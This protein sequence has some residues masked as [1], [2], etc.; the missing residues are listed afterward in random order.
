MLSIVIV[1]LGAS[2]GR[3]AAPKQLGAVVASILAG[4]TWLSPPERRL[5]AACGAG[6]GVAA[7]YNVPFGGALFALEVLLGTLA[8]PLVLPAMTVSPDRHRGVLA[9]AAECPH[10]RVPSYGFSAAGR[11]LGDP[12]WAAR[13]GRR[14]GIMCA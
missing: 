10:L 11:R 13:R 9:D 4:W 2:L 12:G 14:G 5:L 8:L 1:G 6:A 3:E 7:V